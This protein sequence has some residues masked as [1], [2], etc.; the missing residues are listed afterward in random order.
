[1]AGVRMTTKGERREAKRRKRYEMAK[2][3]RSLLHVIRAMG[4]AK[5]RK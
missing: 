5:V 3:G 1:M 4:K 2:N